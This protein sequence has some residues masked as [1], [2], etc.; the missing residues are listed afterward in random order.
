RVLL[1]II[2]LAALYVI[3]LPHL[4]EPLM[5]LAIVAKVAVTVL[6]LAPLGL[7]LGMAYPLGIGRLTEVGGGLVPWA[8]GLNGALSVVASVLATYLGSR[9]GFSAAMWSGVAAYAVGLGCIWGADLRAPTI[10]A[11]STG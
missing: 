5:G 9:F 3:G 7:V 4:I 8:W 1:A 11:Q 6:A 10:R 2:V